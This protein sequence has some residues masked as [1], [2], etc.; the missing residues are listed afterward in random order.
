MH[1]INNTTLYNIEQIGI[2]IKFQG[3]PE[4]GGETAADDNWRL[5]SLIPLPLVTV[6]L[7]CHY[8]TV[9]RGN[10]RLPKDHS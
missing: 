9:R 7:G 8:L 1:Y 4:K 6:M 3:L 2:V 10:Q 5:T